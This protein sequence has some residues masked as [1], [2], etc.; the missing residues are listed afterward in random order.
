MLYEEVLNR[1]ALRTYLSGSYD[2]QTIGPG[3]AV[4]LR[5]LSGVIREELTERQRQILLLYYYQG[6]TMEQIGK[7]L[8]INKS[9]VSR[10]LS[11]AMGK[12]RRTLSCFAG[13]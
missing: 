11:S 10:H 4:L 13:E 5:A 7:H 12:L 6:M 2:P 8:G 3:K 1:Q 9:T